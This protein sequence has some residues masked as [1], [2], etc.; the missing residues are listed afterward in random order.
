MIH[1]DAQMP[2]ELSQAPN[3][4]LTTWS[5]YRSNIHNTAMSNSGGSNSIQKWSSALKAG[6]AVFGSDGTV[7]VGTQD[8]K[9]YALNP[10]GSTL[11]VFVTQDTVD[12]SPAL[13]SDGTIYVGCCDN[14]LYALNP[15]GTQK[16]SFATQGP[17]V[18]SPAIAAD[19]TIYVGSFDSKLYAVNPNGMS[20]W[21]FTPSNREH[22]LWLTGGWERWN[23]LLRKHGSQHLCGQPRWNPKV[24]L[25]NGLECARVSLHRHRRNHIHCF[26]R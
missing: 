15:D 26:A 5:K 1:V 21:I 2:A 12:G 6:P 16:W 22:D 11:W 20:K 23:D 4:T 3:T 19:G 13:G 9:V 7:Y 14:N 8:N 10:D 17:I 24:G 25:R 18:S